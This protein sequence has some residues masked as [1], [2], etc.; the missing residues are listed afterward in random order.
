MV[1]YKVKKI[2]GLRTSTSPSPEE[3]QANIGTLADWVESEFETLASALQATDADPILAV[4]PTKPRRGTTAY[5]NGTNWNPGWGEGPY[6][7]NG[8]AWLPMSAGAVASNACVRFDGPQNLNSAQQVQARQN[9]YAASFDAMMYNGLQVNGGFEVNQQALTAVFNP[10]SLSYAADNW[11]SGGIRAGST[12]NCQ[13]YIGVGLPPGLIASQYIQIATGAI[14]TWG[15]GEYVFHQTYIEGTRCRR[16]NWGTANAMPITIS[17]WL[18]SVASGTGTLTIRN[19]A[20]N[21]TYYK[22][23]PVTAGTTTYTTLQ[24]P[25]DQTGAWATDNTRGMTITWCFGCGANLA[26]GVDG[27]WMAGASGLATPQTSATLFSTLSNYIHIAGVF[28]LPGTEAPSQAQSG[29]IHRPYED[30]LRY[31]RRL[32]RRVVNCMGVAY[33]A[34]AARFFIYHEAMRTQPTPSAAGALQISDV[35]SANYTQSAANV[36]NTGNGSDF[37]QYDAANFAGMTAGR[38]SVVLFNSPA[39]ILDARF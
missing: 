22:N 21:R 13:N 29:E 25:G 30:E 39:I 18:I 7:Y 8:T 32:Y 34:A 31:C 15:N 12:W 5:A 14:T 36:T 10:G 27:T 1:A 26:T 38:A 35:F 6:Y 3:L 33:S 24:I 16:L 11:T 9:I 2:A 23:F 20:A 37:G 17:F 19:N 4:A 28:V